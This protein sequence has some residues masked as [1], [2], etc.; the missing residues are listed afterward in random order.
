MHEKTP[1]KNGISDVLVLAI[2]SGVLSVHLRAVNPR[3]YS[4][5]IGFMGSI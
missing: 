2:F 1:D 5:K 4:L 3:R